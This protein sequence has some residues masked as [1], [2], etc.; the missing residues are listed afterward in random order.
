VKIVSNGNPNPNLRYKLGKILGCQVK[1][2]VE[3]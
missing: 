3:I 1:E 2:V